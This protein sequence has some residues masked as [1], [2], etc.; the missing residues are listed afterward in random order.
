MKTIT[1]DQLVKDDVYVERGKKFIV[2]TDPVTDRGVTTFDYALPSGRVVGPVA[3]FAALEV[4][5]WGT[6]KGL[7]AARNRR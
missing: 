5:R 4:K 7:E 1:Y 2:A 3:V 6:R